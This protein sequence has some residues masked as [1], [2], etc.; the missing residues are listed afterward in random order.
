[1]RPLKERF[2]TQFYKHKN[3]VVIKS[4]IKGG[5]DENYFSEGCNLHISYTNVTNFN[6][7]GEEINFGTRIAKPVNFTYA[8][9][10]HYYTKSLE[11]YANKIRRGDAFVFKRWDYKRQLNRIKYYFIYNKRTK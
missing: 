3:N 10:K 9:I 6:S 8:A 5:L 1:M 7:L 2:T 11:E 4:T